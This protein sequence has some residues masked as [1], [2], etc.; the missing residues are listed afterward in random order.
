MRTI[1]LEVGDRIKLTGTGLPYVVGRRQWVSTGLG[2]SHL[3]I[4][5]VRED[6]YT[7]AIRKIEQDNIVIKLGL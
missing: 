4:K 3:V 6:E 1:S 5:L 7:A 2:T